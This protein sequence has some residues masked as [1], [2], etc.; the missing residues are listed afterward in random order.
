MQLQFTEII[1]Y[2]GLESGITL[3]VSLTFGGIMYRAMAK[4]DPGAEV[5]L[6]SREIAEFLEIDVE[7]GA[8]IVLGS[9]VSTG[10]MQAYGHEVTMQIGGI[11]LDIM[12]Y[13]ARD[14]GLPN[15]VGRRGWLPRVIVG[16]V[17]YEQKVLLALYQPN[18]LI[19]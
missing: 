17:D 12:V 5:C 1:T 8:P 4:L 19:P 15:L 6:F 3:P 18:A 11:N 14:Y 10:T 16:I 7:S 2:S 9:S 13:F